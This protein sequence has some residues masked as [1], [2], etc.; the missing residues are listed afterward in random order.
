MHNYSKINSVYGNLKDQMKLADSCIMA[1]G[2]TPYVIQY[3]I[4]AAE[5]GEGLIQHTNKTEWNK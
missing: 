4:Y 3:V 2:S 1:Y 5:K